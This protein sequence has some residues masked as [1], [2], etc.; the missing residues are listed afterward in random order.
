MHRNKDVLG[1]ELDLYLPEYSFAVEI[2]SWKWHKKALEKDIQ[3]ANE[4]ANK[5]IKL[6][7]IYDSYLEN[8]TLG[9]NFWTYGIDLGSEK[10]CSTL[11]SIV[12]KCLQLINVSYSFSEDEWHNIIS[13]S[14][15]SSRRVTHDDF[16]EQLK[17]KNPHYKTLILLNEYHYAR[18]KIKCKCKKCGHLWET[19]ASELL[20]GTG[21][22][23]C[24]IKMVGEK[25]SKRVQV[26]K[27][28][29]DNPTGTKMQCEKETNISR[30]T[31]YKWWN[32]IN[33]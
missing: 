14:H 17:I 20:K 31:I 2:G 11:K 23:I 16:V 6:I 28:R 4:C 27:W 7:I 24:Q 33:D 10:D 32:S 21:C 5:K 1:K 25:K 29:K 8:V 26:I 30:V 13:L 12:Y 15:R 9:K 19:A 18:D 3:K 22:P